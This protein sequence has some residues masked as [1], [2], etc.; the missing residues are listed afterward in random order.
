MLRLDPG[1]PPLWRDPQT[2]QFGVEAV[3][4]LTDPAPWQQ[5]L[6]RELERGIPDSALPVLASDWGVT[7][8][9]MHAFLETVRPVV[10]GGAFPGDAAEP[11]G[12]PVEIDAVEHDE[13]VEPIVGGLTGFGPDGV[14]VVPAGGEHT[15]S[16]HPT[17]ILVAH[18][19]LDP[20]RARAA[21]RDD[22][23]HLPVVF[24]SGRATVGPMVIP[25]RTA[26]LTC[27]DEHRID[28][29]AAWPMLVGQLL[30]RPRPVVETALAFDAGVVAAW[31]IREALTDRHPRGVSVALSTASPRR[32]RRTHRP[33]ARCGCRS[34]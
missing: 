12:W 28:A 1:S 23:D 33:H 14:T 34:P 18:H 24:H 15:A 7:M 30:G 9:A 3:V 32:S 29:D 25:G 31:L 8:T 22:I 17:R 6:V 16:G 11:L 26:C 19:V 21:M 27:L 4:T 10:D 13:T 20:A 5:R 2:L